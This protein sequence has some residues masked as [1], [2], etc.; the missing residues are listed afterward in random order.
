[1][2]AALSLPLVP[3]GSA[4]SLLEPLPNFAVAPPQLTEHGAGACRLVETAGVRLP[5]DGHGNVSAV[6]HSDRSRSVLV[7]H[8]PVDKS[9]LDLPYGGA[10][11]ES[12]PVAIQHL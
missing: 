3:A 11:G 9:I 2:D 8:I 5:R 4:S 7:P 6:S 1:M 10:I 12:C